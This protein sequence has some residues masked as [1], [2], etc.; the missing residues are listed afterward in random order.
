[1]KPSI[2]LYMEYI[3]ISWMIFFLRSVWQNV[4]VPVVFF[5]HVPRAL[6]EPIKSTATPTH[7]HKHMRRA[8][9]N[10]NELNHFIALFSSLH[11]ATHN[12]NRNTKYKKYFM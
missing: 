5:F 12:R 3:S 6:V 9:A 10:H 8:T 1:M 4:Q 11:R 7:T 2:Y